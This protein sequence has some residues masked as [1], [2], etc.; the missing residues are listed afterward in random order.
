MASVCARCKAEI[1]EGES[2]VAMPDG[3]RVLCVVLINIENE[4]AKMEKERSKDLR[5]SSNL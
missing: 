2:H 3:A 5:K 4:L 1:R